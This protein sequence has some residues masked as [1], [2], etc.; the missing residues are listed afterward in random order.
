MWQELPEG[1]A[2][3]SMAGKS[4]GIWSP[5][6]SGVWV[7]AGDLQ[8]DYNRRIPNSLRDLGEKRKKK[9]SWVVLRD[10]RDKGAKPQSL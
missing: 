8:R 3:W 1:R 9:Q 2:S 4:C 7:A 5:G 10:Q 6:A